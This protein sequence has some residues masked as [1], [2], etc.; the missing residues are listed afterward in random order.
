MENKN[1][2]WK[3]LE[4]LN[5]D[6]KFAANKR[7]EFAEGIP[8]EEVLTEEDGELTSNRRDFLKYFGFSI[9]AVA[10]AA[11]NKAP[12]KNVIPY[13]IKP[14]NITPGVPNFYATTTDTGV[15][16]LV[17]TREGRPIKIEGNTQSPVYKGGVGAVEHA[18]LLGLYDNERLQNP[19]VE[20]NNSEWAT[21]DTKVKAGLASAK[22]IRIVTGTVNSPSTKK[23]MAE[24]A[25]KYPGTK[26]VTY[27]ATSKCCDC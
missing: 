12:V 2:Y 7:N 8:L 15:S 10:L 6:P 19:V 11:C 5:N 25:A 22:N 20:G 21:L 1:T 14:E 27:E 3:G 13:I 17:K 16:I 23:A 26:V 4:E 9:S 18:S 24:F